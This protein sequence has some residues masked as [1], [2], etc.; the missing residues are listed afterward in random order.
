MPNSS[1]VLHQPLG[2][3]QGQASDI[4]RHAADILEVK[5]RMIRLYAHHCGRS[6][7]DVEE[8]LDRDFFMTAEQARDWGIVD[9]IRGSREEIELPAS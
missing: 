1:I 8:T 2:G 5:R 4:Q 9:H 3:F 6:E 7:Q